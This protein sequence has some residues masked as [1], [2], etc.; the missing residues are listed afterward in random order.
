M[1]FEFAKNP[2]VN[3]IS[4]V[5]PNIPI[6]ILYGSE[7]WLAKLFD[8]NSLYSIRKNGFLDIQAFENAGH[9]LLAEQ[10]DKFNE[11]VNEICNLTEEN[12]KIWG[13]QS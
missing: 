8:F 9:Q 6:T 2:M 13:L 12:Y 11:A 7:S 10:A 5:N 4:D 3:R 1:G